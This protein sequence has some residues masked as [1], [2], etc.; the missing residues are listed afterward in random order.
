MAYNPNN[1]V[2]TEYVNTNICR[3]FKQYIFTSLTS[4]TGAAVPGL[5]TTSSPV[6]TGGMVC[7]EVTIINKTTGDLSLYDRGFTNVNNSLLIGTGESIT[8]RGLTNV[9]QV[10]AIAASA[11]TVYYRTQY[12]S[13]NPSR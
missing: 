3:S 5:T 12:F 11:G 1:A 2:G 4:L 7:S 8:L 13:S 6:L 10:S 9:A